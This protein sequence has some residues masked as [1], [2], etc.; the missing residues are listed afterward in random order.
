MV[1]RYTP[2]MYV[3][4]VDQQSSRT[5]ADRVPEL[6][7]ALADVS[8]VL[9]FVRTVGDEAQAVFDSAHQVVRSC[10]AIARTGQWSI[11]IGLG[12]VEHPLPDSSDQARGQAFIA[13]R[14]AVEMAKNSW[15]PLC[16]ETAAT[17]EDHV[18]DVQDA[19]TVLRLMFDLTARATDAQWQVIH[20]LRN[21][22]GA[23]QAQIAQDLNISQQAVS[24]SLRAARAEGIMEAIDCAERLL[25][26][27]HQPWES[28]AH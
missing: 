24:K 15:S 11:G 5:E 16:V 27:A 7:D 3:L 12:E 20:A 2:T 8:T 4:T 6:L 1:V 10:V 17:G 28:H 21:T 18:K 26:R 13:A 14:T 23:S 19:Q 25:D 9:P 22:P